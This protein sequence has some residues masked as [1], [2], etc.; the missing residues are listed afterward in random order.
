MLR[1]RLPSPQRAGMIGAARNAASDEAPA[2][3]PAASLASI[4]LKAKSAPGKKQGDLTKVLVALPL[5]E[6]SAVTA[7]PMI[8][9]ETPAPEVTES[10]PVQTAAVEPLPE[11]PMPSPPMP[12]PS[13]PEPALAASALAEQPIAEGPE[14]LTAAVATPTELIAAETDFAIINATDVVDYW[15]H[16]RKDRAYPAVNEL[17]RGFI[18]QKWPDTW[19]LVFSRPDHNAKGEPNLSRVTRLGAPGPASEAELDYSSYV[20][21]WIMVLGRAAQSS[22]VGVEEI[23]RLSTRSGSLSY[24]VRAL[25]LGPADDAPDHVLCELTRVDS[26]SR[27]GRRRTWLTD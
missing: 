5:P 13:T 23:E 17:D 3:P 26:P 14:P 21:E 8:V 9:P 11:P 25:P 1:D 15:R 18:A 20:T 6:A 4:S 19:L 12:G 24:R 10:A 27:F 22:G 16:Q 7:A 2:R